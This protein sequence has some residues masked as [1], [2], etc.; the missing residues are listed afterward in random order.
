MG[1]EGR[2]CGVRPWW[3]WRLWGE[4][5]MVDEFLHGEITL[6]APVR[7]LLLFTLWLVDSVR[8]VP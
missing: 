8:F 7:I 3:I 4:G 5:S 1:I 2:W 6:L